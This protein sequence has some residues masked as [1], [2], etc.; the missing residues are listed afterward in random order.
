MRHPS[1]ADGYNSVAHCTNNVDLI[2]INF[3]FLWSFTF[4]LGEPLVD[5]RTFTSV[6]GG[7]LFSPFSFSFSYLPARGYTALRR[8]RGGV[9]M[10]LC[11]FS[12]IFCWTWVCFFS[13]SWYRHWG[14]GVIVSGIVVGFIVIIIIQG[15]QSEMKNAPEN[16]LQHFQIQPI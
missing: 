16:W 4:I 1:K 9:F 13:N 12:L 10:S 5:Y 11:N 7:I 15:D 6:Q 8:S 14:I 2:V 3:Y